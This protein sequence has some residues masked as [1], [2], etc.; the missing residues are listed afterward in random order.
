[1]FKPVGDGSVF[2]DIPAP[3]VASYI[4]VPKIPVDPEDEAIIDKLVNDKERESSPVLEYEQPVEPGVTATVTEE[5]CVPSVFTAHTYP[6]ESDAHSPP[7][8]PSVEIQ[9]LQLTGSLEAV[10]DLLKG[11]LGDKRRV[12]VRVTVLGG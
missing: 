1:M 5:Q 9:E 7:E 3:V 11:T 6:L 4:C 8:L 2:V 12:S 10:V